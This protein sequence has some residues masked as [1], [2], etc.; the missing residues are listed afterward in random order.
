MHV[1]LSVP[2]FQNS[3]RI[4]INMSTT[5]PYLD[6][7]E[8]KIKSLELD[9]MTSKTTNFNEK[10]DFSKEMKRAQ[11]VTTKT[12]HS[13]RGLKIKM[14]YRKNFKCLCGNC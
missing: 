6:L 3:K 5:N 7:I 12:L 1:F 9:A 8:E 2:H 13:G 11:K 4:K 14:K 10:T